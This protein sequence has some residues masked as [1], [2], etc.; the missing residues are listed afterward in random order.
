MRAQVHPQTKQPLVCTCG[1]H[2]DISWLTMCSSCLAVLLARILG[3][4]I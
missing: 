1:Q 4:I 3:L 2:L